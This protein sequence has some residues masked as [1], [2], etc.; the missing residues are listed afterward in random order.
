MYADVVGGGFLIFYI[1][2]VIFDKTVHRF[3]KQYNC[4][5]AKSKQWGLLN[6]YHNL[7]HTDTLY[8]SFFHHMDL[9]IVFLTAPCD[10]ICNGMSTT[11][12]TVLC[13]YIILLFSMHQQMHVNKIPIFIHE[14]PT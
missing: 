1:F 13:K 8:E 4:T 9:D 12:L 7:L 6:I 11:G 3:F 2:C 5:Y 14:N 10:N